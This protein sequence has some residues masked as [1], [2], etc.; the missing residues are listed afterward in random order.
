MF[1][2]LANL[3][4]G[5]GTTLF[6]MSE[7]DRAADDAAMAAQRAAQA[8][9]K[10]INQAGDVRRAGIGEAVG[11][12]KPWEESG[13]RGQD[14][15]ND[16]LGINGPEAQRNY[17]QN[18]QNDPGFGAVQQAGIGTV[19]QSRAAGGGLR[20]GAT[21]KALMD[22]GQRLQQSVFQ[23]RLNRLGETGRL[24][25]TSAANMAGITNSGYG[26]LAGYEILKGDAVAGGLLGASNAQQMGTQN[27]LALLGYGAGH[28]KG[29]LNDLFSAFGK[30]A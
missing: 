15:L 8:R 22:Y 24:G 6:G 19:E 12:L 16:A 1:A 5:I 2:E 28:V 25:A 21:M 18:F 23:D 29:G 4:I 14:L 9:K 17:F 20:S 7:S 10:G 13:R 26:D 30:A 3:G 11:Y 27:K